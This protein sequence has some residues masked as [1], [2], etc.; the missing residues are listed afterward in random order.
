[1]KDGENKTTKSDELLKD[2]VFLTKEKQEFYMKASERFTEADENALTLYE[3]STSQKFDVMLELLLQIRDNSSQRSTLGS[4][5]IAKYYG[6]LLDVTLETSEGQI[7]TAV[8][9][10]IA[11]GISITTLL[12]LVLTTVGR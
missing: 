4:E 6:K 5:V 12:I 8:I 11:L 10:G 3:L 9:S 1:M 7:R 2:N